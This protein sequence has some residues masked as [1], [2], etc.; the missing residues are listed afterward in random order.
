MCVRGEHGAGF[1]IGPQA[2][3]RG[4]EYRKASQRISEVEGLASF[5]ERQPLDTAGRV[6]RDHLSSGQRLQ[7]GFEPGGAEDFSAAK[8][9]P[10][11]MRQNWLLTTRC[12]HRRRRDR[13][14][15]LAELRM[16]L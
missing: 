8:Y 11:W 12:A 1:A 10:V 9:F 7:S 4:Q 14:T 15:F 6:D 3:S 16:M 2:G 5:S 13:S